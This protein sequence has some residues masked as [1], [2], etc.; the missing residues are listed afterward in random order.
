MDDLNIKKKENEILKN[1]VR[2]LEKQNNELN[3]GLSN[4]RTA[5][6][7]LSECRSSIDGALHQFKD[8]LDKPLKLVV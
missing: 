5:K 6:E 4:M 1:K 3:V 8:S 2:I 7:A